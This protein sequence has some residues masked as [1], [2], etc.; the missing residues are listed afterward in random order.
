MT[1][2]EYHN[3]TVHTVT[4]FS[5]SPIISFV[6]D[7]PQ[8]D[9]ISHLEVANPENGHSKSRGEASSSK[10]LQDVHIVRTL[11]LVYLDFLDL[12]KDERKLY[13]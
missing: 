12:Q 2:N 6:Q 5:P 13:I 7:V 4:Q 10:S 1:A 8:G 11:E 3:V 9:N